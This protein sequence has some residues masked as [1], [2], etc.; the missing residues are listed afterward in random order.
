M[1]KLNKLRLGLLLITL[2]VGFSLAFV[3]DLFA[4]KINHKESGVRTIVIDPG[5]GGHDSG[6]HG[7]AA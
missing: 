1:K 4:D 2:T 3:P 6:C 7:A 5:H